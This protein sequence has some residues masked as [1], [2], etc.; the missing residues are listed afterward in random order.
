MELQI[1]ANS[2][3]QIDL[4]PLRIRIPPDIYLTVAA[5]VLSGAASSTGAALTW[6]EDL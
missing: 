3:V 1:A 4:T 2:T 5:N 6:Y